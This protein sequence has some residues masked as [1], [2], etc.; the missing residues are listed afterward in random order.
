MPINVSKITDNQVQKVLEMSEGHF[1]DFKSKNVRPANI[2]K[3]LSAFTNADGGELF[4]GIEDSPRIWDGFNE[5]EDANALIQII[6]II[7]KEN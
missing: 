1:L 2:T 7:S 3:H 5:Q 6:Y 4:I